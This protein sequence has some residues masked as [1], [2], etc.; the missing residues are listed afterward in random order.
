MIN[1]IIRKFIPRQ[2][3]RH[4]QASLSRIFGKNSINGA[5]GNKL[6]FNGALMNHCRIQIA[7]TGNTIIFG[8]GNTLFNSRII[9]NGSSNTIL[10][11]ADNLLKEVTLWMED[12]AGM[13]C[14]GDN[15][16]FCG[17]IQIASVEGQTVKIG[18][19]NLFSSDIHITTTDSHSI[20][21]RTTGRRINP[22]LP[23]TIG[24]HNWI[25]TRATILK[26][27]VLTRDIIVG[28]NSVVTKSPGKTNCILGGNPAGIIKENTTWDIHRL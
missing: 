7:G 17:K 24:D 27:A 2:K 14:I 19:G 11:G 21:D 22:S 16:K 28:A 15:N 13:I 9:I 23:V 4:I 20:L 5:R 3:A 12:E 25:G 10:I 8:G 1:P 26:G 6:V 18:N